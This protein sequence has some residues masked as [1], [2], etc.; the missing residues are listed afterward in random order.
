M[1]EVASDTPRQQWGI[2]SHKH[3]I[4]PSVCEHPSPASP[5]VSLSSGI[6][7]SARLLRLQ[8][9]ASRVT[10][11]QKYTSACQ[12]PIEPTSS[13]AGSLH[14]GNLYI[15]RCEEALFE[16]LKSEM[17]FSRRMRDGLRPNTRHLEKHD[18]AFID[19]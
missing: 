7:H 17:H 19:I 10:E 5:A 9:V 13:P 6:A 2:L 12:G 16:A 1:K 18:E 3:I 4:H 8:R 15:H 11:T 14:T